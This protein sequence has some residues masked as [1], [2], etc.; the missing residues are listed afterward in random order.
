MLVLQLLDLLCRDGMIKRPGNES[1][2]QKVMAAERKAYL[3]VLEI[4]QTAS[5]AENSQSE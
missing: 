1:Y 2:L 3:E 4:G 5:E